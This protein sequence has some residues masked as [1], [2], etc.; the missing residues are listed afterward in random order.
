MRVSRKIIVF[1][2]FVFCSLPLFGMKRK[3]SLPLPNDSSLIENITK[4]TK[5]ALFPLS[6]RYLRE[7]TIVNFLK[8][9]TTSLRE[10]NEIEIAAPERWLWITKYFDLKP[11]FLG[12]G[13]NFNQIL[14][15]YFK[16]KKS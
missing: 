4:E 8:D 11:N 14:E 13:V 6:D 3:R 9:L 16:R 2:L 10:N 5:V 12:F 1:Y 15:D 7:G